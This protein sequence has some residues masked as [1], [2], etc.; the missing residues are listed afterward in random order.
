MA[1]HVHE[2]HDVGGLGQAHP[3]FQSHIIMIQELG[4]TPFKTNDQI[5]VF[6]VALNGLDLEQMVH[7]L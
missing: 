4:E 6:N 2:C 3:T 1:K 7:R 5:N